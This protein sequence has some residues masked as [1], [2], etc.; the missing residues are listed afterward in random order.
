MEDEMDGNI[1]DAVATVQP[2]TI[3]RWRHTFPLQLVN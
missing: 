2:V 3:N 1:A